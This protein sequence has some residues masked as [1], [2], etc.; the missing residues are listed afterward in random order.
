MVRDTM[1]VY[2]ILILGADAILARAGFS[3]SHLLTPW[4]H[5]NYQHVYTGESIGIRSR[6]RLHLCGTVRDSPVREL[7]LAYQFSDAALW[8]VSDENL[9]KLESRLNKWLLEN[10]LIAFRVGGYVRDVEKDFI[11]RLPSTL[12]TKGN[13][14]SPF[15]PLLKK[16]RKAFRDYLKA[17]GQVR[18]CTVKPCSAWLVGSTAHHLLGDPSQSIQSTNPLS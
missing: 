12:N 11:Q 6:L 18:H 5:Q 10:A 2:M 13:S 9:D 1:G 7:L 15:L 3:E 4:S 17:T 8:P 14:D 16:K